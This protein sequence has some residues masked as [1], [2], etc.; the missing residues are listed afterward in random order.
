MHVENILL[1]HITLKFSDKLSSCHSLFFTQSAL[2][3]VQTFPY[4]STTS[5][6]NMA[7]RGDDEI[8]SLLAMMRGSGPSTTP[9]T[10]TASSSLTKK[11]KTKDRKK[12]KDNGGSDKMKAKRMKQK[13]KRNDSN[14]ITAKS[15][16]DGDN[17]RSKNESF[18]ET[19]LTQNC[20]AWPCSKK[21]HRWLCLGSGLAHDCKG[22]VASPPDDVQGSYGSTPC[23]SCGKS[24]ATHE[25]FLMDGKGD[26]VESSAPFSVL[27]IASIIVAA[28]NARCLFGEY[29]PSSLNMM[30][31]AQY[32]ELDESPKDSL[33]PPINSIQSSPE[34]I[35]KSLDV[36]VG[37]ALASVKI[38]RSE[39]SNNISSS[40]AKSR[41][42]QRQE[43]SHKQETND[44]DNQSN[45]SL[46]LSIDDVE[47][48][49]EK[50]TTLVKNAMDYKHAMTAACSSSRTKNDDA[51]K[52]VETR[53]V[54]MASCDNLYYRCYYATIVFS[55]SVG[56]NHDGGNM[57]I[58]IPHPPTYFSCP[59]LAWDV[60]NAGVNALRIFLDESHENQG[61]GK[62]EF[63]ASL[64][65]LTKYILLQTWGLNSRLVS[66]SRTNTNPL[67]S[68]WQSRFLESIRHIWITRYSLAV[69]PSA[70]QRCSN[71]SYDLSPGNSNKQD[72]QMKLNET[73]AIS[74]AV[75]Q[76]RDSVRDYPANFY[77]YAA[78]TENALNA[79][80][81]SLVCS[82]STYDKEDET[83]QK[84]LEAGAGTGYWSALLLS[85]SKHK[86]IKR[87]SATQETVP[88]VIPYDVSPPSYS[89]DD[90]NEDGATISNE[91]HGH[92]PTFTYVY[93]AHSFN[94]ALTK[95]SQ[96]STSSLLLCYPP[97]GSDM[98]L[99]TISAHISNG[100]Q[101][102]VHI[103]EWQ[104]LTGNNAF[105]MLLSEKFRCKESD[106]IPLPLWGTDATYLTI[107]R[108]KRNEECDGINPVDFSPAFGYCS[109]QPCSN[110]AIRR[111]RFA[112]CLQYCSLECFQRHHTQR[113]A[114]LALH[115][116]KLSS[117][118]ILVYGD[119]RH[120][121]SLGQNPEMLQE[122][123]S[124]RPTKRRKKRNNRKN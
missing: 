44:Y 15:H 39:L 67:L 32:H 86:M 38:I 90:Q 9:P 33:L 4:P 122:A 8:D 26:V 109:S 103:G 37:R 66:L 104:G 97:P 49:R 41:K 111:C 22:Y 110:R 51:I 72:K 115:M 59:G 80:V 18:A 7:L 100:G 58:M 12:E 96:D 121:L 34:R 92:I 63:A 19:R 20:F 85:R 17:G 116:I 54:A 3:E 119:D 108:R 124:E 5:H 36:F 47:L 114:I 48:L 102:V 53:L 105:E 107:W 117:E 13:R 43:Q 11:N 40:S 42:K 75:V 1:G 68:L 24:A 99:A 70:L 112:R 28:R 29:Y 60:H 82:R 77:A 45:L 106:V 93:K 27:S 31:K 52:L 57:A 64:D 81:E 65:D 79:V 87:G 84:V 21:G 69:S 23:Q 62:H 78:P 101:T 55:S 25:L 74:S 118:S 46:S 83:G 98:A 16:D 123:Q 95:T 14:K 56:D 91:Y 35:S 50:T 2:N 76:W 73:S 113:S 6:Q 71:A 89:E 94:H 30:Q 10:A 61:F 120:F 88:L